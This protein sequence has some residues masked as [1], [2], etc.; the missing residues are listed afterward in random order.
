MD[1]EYAE[2]QEMLRASAREFLEKECTESVIKEVQESGLGY[3][4]EVWKKIA[5]LGW[6]GLV[7]PEQYG[8]AG[9][10]VID[11]AVLYEEFGRVM[12]PS[13]YMS[14]VVLGGLT[15]LEAG[16]DG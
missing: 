9:M 5:D 2:E 3:S 8:G 16:S 15:I 14:T 13:S 6:L 7:Y 1:F 12:F 4:P 11:L 10:N